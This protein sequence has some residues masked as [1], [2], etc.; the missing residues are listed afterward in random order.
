LPFAPHVWPLGQTPHMMVP[1][2]PSGD[3]PHCPV[4]HVF[5]AHVHWLPLHT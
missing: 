5:F 2:H 1:P 3:V 4:A